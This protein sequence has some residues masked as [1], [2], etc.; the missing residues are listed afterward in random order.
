MGAKT[1]R[2]WR[3]KRRKL[4]KRAAGRCEYCQASAGIH[5]GTVDHWV[6]KFCGGNSSYSNL[7]WSCRVCNEAKGHAHPLFIVALVRLSNLSIGE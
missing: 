2:L 4:H 5:T 3:Y 1:N 7:L 6:P